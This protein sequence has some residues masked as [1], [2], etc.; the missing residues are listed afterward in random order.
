MA[1]DLFPKRDKSIAPKIYAYSDE[2]YPGCLKL[3]IPVER[4]SRFE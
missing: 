3:D 2:L 1:K 4:M